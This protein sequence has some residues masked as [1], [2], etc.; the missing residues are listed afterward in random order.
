VLTDR[1]LSWL[2]SERL[3][4]QLTESDADTHSQPLVCGKVMG[5][6][7][8][9]EGKSNPIRRTTATTNSDPQS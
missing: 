9:A 3:Y 1:S 4:R 6:F 7:E 5:R 8:R 2:S